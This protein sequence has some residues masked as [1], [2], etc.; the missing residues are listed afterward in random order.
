VQWSPRAAETA[1]LAVV[2]LGLA[3]AVV[4]VDPL[5]RVLVGA[6]ALLLLAL[7]ARDGL[8]RPR[9]SAL[10]GGVVVRTLGGRR[11]LPWAALQVR[12]RSTRRWGLRSRLL[13]LDT[14]AGADDAGELVLLGRRDLGAD[15]AEVAAALRALAAEA[16]R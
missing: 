2:G 4:L 11:E 15:P 16:Q 1:A 3:L 9:L 13:E 7:A 6:A 5:G 10:A 12:V 14:A 8:L